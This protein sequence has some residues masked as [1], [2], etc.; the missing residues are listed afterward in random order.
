M[1]DIGFLPDIR[2]IVRELP[3]DRQTM[4]FSATIAPV[5]HLARDVTH[6]PLRVEVEK[7]ATPE[8]IDQ[9]FY[10]VLEHRKQDVLAHLL[11]GQGV[12]SVLVF[13]RTKRRADLVTSRLVHGGVNAGVIHGDRTQKERVRVLDSF[14][15]GETRVLV[16]TDVAARGI[17]VTGISHV[18]NYDLPMK[19]EDYVH[20]IGRTGRADA[21]GTAWSLVAPPDETMATRIQKVVDLTIQRLSPEGVDAGRPAYAPKKEK[22]TVGNGWNRRPSRRRRRF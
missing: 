2:R 4:L 1:L 6:R 13:T 18:V 5:Y 10:P 8:S 7:T 12:E 16:A 19:A 15:R 17:D 22:V 20:R 9:A 11:A 21:T 14:R 3:T